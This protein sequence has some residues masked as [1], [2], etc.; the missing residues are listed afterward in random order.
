MKKTPA[1][2]GLGQHF[3]P[4][5]FTLIE[6]LVVIAIIAIL[7]SMLLPAL[8]KARAKGMEATCKSN[9]K[10]IFQA[11]FMYSEDNDMERMVYVTADVWPRLLATNYTGLLPA[12]QYDAGNNP[13]GG[14]YYCPAESYKCA[15][16]TAWYMSFRGC[17][18]GMN[19]Y[20]TYK[21]LAPP[22]D[23]HNAAGRWH[24]KQQLAN[25]GYT[26]YYSDTIH[27]SDNTV[28]TRGGKFRHSNGLNSI[29]LD[30]HIEH[31]KNGKIPVS[32][33]GSTAWQ[34]YYYW[35]WPLWKWRFL[36]LN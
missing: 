36:M 15:V 27:Y 6:L 28:D 7:A 16:G 17:H 21:I 26:M 25:P 19:I 3:L 18:Y 34:E 29:F 10:Q 12:M 24:P 4:R 22:T 35:R 14:V 5:F 30:G 11:S 31:L 2:I 23:A 20:L 1:V 8:S 13:T 33:G 9:L 32:T